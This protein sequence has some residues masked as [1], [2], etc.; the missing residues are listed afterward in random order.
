MLNLI[1]LAGELFQEVQL[2][3][4]FPDSK[5]FVDARPKYSAEQI[6][7]QYHR[8]S[9][10]ID[11]NLQQF[12]HNNFISAPSLSQEFK[13][14]QQH[15]LLEHIAL[16]WDILT[17]DPDLASEAGSSLIPL[18]Y[19]YIVPGGRFSEVYYWDSYFTAQGLLVDNQL[20]LVINMV[21]NF[22]FLLHNYGLI[23]NA[24]RRYYLSRSQPPFFASLLEL[25]FI[26][27]GIQGILEYLPALDQEYRFWMKNQR[28]I[29]L[30]P[31]V[32]MNRY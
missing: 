21:K 10:N 32:V 2:K 1:Q 27:F 15:G 18:P 8:Q 31:G 19:A 22:A 20:Q 12:I 14:N 23:P 11:F 29:Q 7:K 5:T 3:N 6:M 16:L 26:Q 25:I 9:T 30:R 4:V 17:R 28:Q 24:N 13:S